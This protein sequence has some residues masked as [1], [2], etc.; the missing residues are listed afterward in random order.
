MKS[1]T[2]VPEHGIYVNFMTKILLSIL[3]NLVQCDIRYIHRKFLPEKEVLN[4]NIQFKKGVLELCVLSILGRKNCYGYELVNEISKNIDIAEGTIYPLLK[5][6]KD[7]GFVTT[8]LE[9]SA[10]GPP[11]KYYNL[12]QSGINLME[13]LESEWL[14]FVKE[15]NEIVLRGRDE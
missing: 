9:E 3:H 6:L 12:S 14:S 2:I 8:Y 5:R 10:E 4:L 15:V 13:H 1:Q 11:R 7:E